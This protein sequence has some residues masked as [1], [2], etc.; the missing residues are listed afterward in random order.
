M[1]DPDIADTFQYNDEDDASLL[2]P[3]ILPQFDL[4]VV[5]PDTASEEEEN[6][7]N[8]RTGTEDISREPDE[9]DNDRLDQVMLAEVERTLKDTFNEQTKVHT[10]HSYTPVNPF[11]N[12]TVQIYY[13]N[14]EKYQSFISILLEK[15]RRKRLTGKIRRSRRGPKDC[16][17]D[18][19]QGC[20]LHHEELFSVSSRKPWLLKNGY[21]FVFLQLEHHPEFMKHLYFLWMLSL[22]AVL[23]TQFMDPVNYQ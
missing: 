2:I 20:K 11:I 9:A 4:E 5:Y 14:T 19:E 23:A 16:K 22:M 17:F 8:P 15:K 21:M 7:T 12:L 1:A 10:A 13:S 18:K 3:L 6:G